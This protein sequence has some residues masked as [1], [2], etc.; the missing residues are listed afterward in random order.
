L[1]HDKI[2]GTIPPLQILGDLFPLPRDLR[3]CV[4]RKNDIASQ[5][6]F[7]RFPK[8]QYVTLVS[9]NAQMCIYLTNLHVCLITL[10]IAVTCHL[11]YIL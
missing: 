5:L 7:S 11:T 3:P 2:W 4:C 1:Q 6:T 10:V 9:T 8:A